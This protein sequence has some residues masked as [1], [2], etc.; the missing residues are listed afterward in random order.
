M[1]IKKVFHS[2]ILEVVTAV[3]TKATIVYSVMPSASVQR[4]KR[5]GRCNVSTFRVYK[6]G[7]MLVT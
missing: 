3:T 2:F 6:R 5:F 1:L 4:H 7:N